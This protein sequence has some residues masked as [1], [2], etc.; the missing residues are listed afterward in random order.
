MVLLLAWFATAPK[1]FSQGQ[2]PNGDFEGWFT[3]QFASH[4][5]PSS[6][7]W[8]TLNTLKSIGGPET[9]EKTPDAHTGNYAAKLT[10]RQWGTLTI[11]GLLV[12]GEFDIQNPNF[13]VQGQPFTDLPLAFKGWFK[14]AP[15]SGDSAGIAALLTRWNTNLQRRDTLALAA[16]VVM[17]SYP[18]W[19]AFDLPFVYLQT[20]LNPDSI[21]V[22][23]VSSGDGQN[24][25]GQVGSTLW[26]D[27]VSLDYATSQTATSAAPK[28]TVQLRGQDLW[29][30]VPQVAGACELRIHDLQGHVLRTERLLGGQQRIALDLADGIYLAEIRNGNR[31]HQRQ[32]IAFIRP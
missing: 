10:T 5:E 32:K 28:T 4:E 9:V 27:D 13:L 31:I 26:I 14:Y 19:T 3:P 16:L 20:G 30:N 7:W 15:V 18:A 29:V 2:I 17:G 12:S 11:P 25:N 6:G 24:F 21:L 22:A 8:T 1:G 23:M